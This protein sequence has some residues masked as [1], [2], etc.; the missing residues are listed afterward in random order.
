MSNITPAQLRAARGLIDWTR[1]D[2][3]DAAGISPETIKNI[4]HGT[5]HPQ[6]STTTSIIKAFANKDVEFTDNEGVRKKKEIIKIYT[7]DDGV[8]EI[9]EHEYNLIKDG[10]VITRHM[11]LRD[12]N[13][14]FFAADSLG[15]YE[16]KRRKIANLDARCLV[17]EGESTFPFNSYCKYR[18]L[19]KKYRGITPFYL[20]KNYI[21]FIIHSSP[22]APIIV[23]LQSDSLSS[24][25]AQQ[26]DVLWE[27][28]IE[29]K[30]R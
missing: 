18:L 26:F 17:L 15:N 3:A 10:G 19:D 5:F 14:S 13:A 20:Y 28:S 6:E 24:E 7:G 25:L 16:E 23:S 27:Q 9:I 2:L 4:E 8:R 21:S 30:P 22:S 12:N 29:F 1:K 11:A